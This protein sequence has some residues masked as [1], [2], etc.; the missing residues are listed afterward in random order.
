MIQITFMIAILN[1]EA[2]LDILES[3]HHHQG[4]ALAQQ[5]V[6]SDE[7]IQLASTLCSKNIDI[8]LFTDIQLP[9]SLSHPTLGDRHFKDRVLTVQLNVVQHVIGAVPDGCSSCQLLFR[10]NYFVRTVPQEELLLHIRCGAG[11]NQLGT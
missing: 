2:F 10:V 6:R 5:G 4:F 7:G 3:S 9:Y 8:E 1:P 11:H